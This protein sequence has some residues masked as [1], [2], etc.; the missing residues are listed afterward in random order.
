MLWSLQLWLKAVL[1]CVFS[2]VSDATAG[3]CV[4]ARLTF[5]SEPSSDPAASYLLLMRHG[6]VLLLLLS[7]TVASHSLQ[8]TLSP[9][10]RKSPHTELHY[11]TSFHATKALHTALWPQLSE[12]RYMCVCVLDCCGNRVVSAMEFSDVSIEISL[13]Q[14]H[15]IKENSRNEYRPLWF[16]IIDFCI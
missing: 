8:I 14:Q 11:R 12:V 15:R 10:W 2:D 9:L 13:R 16:T 5:G 1:L 6:L 7:L 4:C 3:K